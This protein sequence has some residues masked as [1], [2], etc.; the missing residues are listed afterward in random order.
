MSEIQKEQP[1]QAFN[2]N[3]HELSK[4]LS[5]EQIVHKLNDEKTKLFLKDDK[6]NVTL[7][8]DDDGV[9]MRVYEKG[10]DRDEQNDD[11]RKMKKFRLLRKLHELNDAQ[12]DS[13]M[14]IEQVPN[15]PEEII[16]FKKNTTFNPRNL[17]SY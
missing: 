4:A 14:K 10:K 8:V 11:L 3:L 5:R 6:F 1:N 7:V 12:L 2:T 16:L 15:D 17:D 13:T 9:F